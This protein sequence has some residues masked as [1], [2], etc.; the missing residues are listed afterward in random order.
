MYTLEMKLKRK[1]GRDTVKIYD[2]IDFLS[3]T[4]LNHRK[5]YAYMT[6]WF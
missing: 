1:N 6:I 5:L 4:V 3:Y 2:N